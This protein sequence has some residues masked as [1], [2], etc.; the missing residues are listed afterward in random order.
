MVRIHIDSRVAT[1][2]LDGWLEASKDKDEKLRHKG[3]CKKKKVC[4]WT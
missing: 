3:V 4:G 2:S 1:E